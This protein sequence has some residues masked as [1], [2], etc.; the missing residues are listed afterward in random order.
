LVA[1]QIENKAAIVA[2]LNRRIGQIDNAVE[3]AT[4]RGR[5]KGAM[6]LATQQ[7]RAR[8]DLLTQRQ[9]V[10]S[11]LADLRIRLA[12]IDAQR[13]RVEAEVGPVRYLAELFGSHDLEHAVRLVTAIARLTSTRCC[14]DQQQHGERIEQDH[15]QKRIRWWRGVLGFPSA[16]PR[17]TLNTKH[18]EQNSSL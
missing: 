6:D 3:E 1:Q 17:F 9:V 16:M 10:A 7:N 18:C 15:D 12:A 11:E 5:T 14:R 13:Q 8:A 2:D 4:R